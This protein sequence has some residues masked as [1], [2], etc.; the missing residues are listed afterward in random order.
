MP[1]MWP[2]GIDV[3][4]Y[5]TGHV[6]T[7]ALSCPG[8]GGALIRQPDEIAFQLSA[9]VNLL[10]DHGGPAPTRNQGRLPIP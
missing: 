4:V 9:N 1:R 10:L 5:P 2:L 7:D 8:D 3:L 6:G